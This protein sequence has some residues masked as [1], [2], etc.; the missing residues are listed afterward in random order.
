MRLALALYA[1]FHLSRSTLLLAA[2]TQHTVVKIRTK[3][4]EVALSFYLIRGGDYRQLGLR[5]E[6]FGSMSW[7]AE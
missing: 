2:V 1:A 7:L 5:G 3:C 4:D 6:M